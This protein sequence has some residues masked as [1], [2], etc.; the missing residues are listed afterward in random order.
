MESSRLPTGPTHHQSTSVSDN[1]HL[2]GI[3]ETR[4]RN[5][6][7]GAFLLIF[8]VGA[9][10]FIV[11]T[12]VLNGVI[13]VDTARE[14]GDAGDVYKRYQWLILG[15]LT[16][17]QYGL[18]L[19]LSLLVIRRW[20]TRRLIS[21]LTLDTLSVAGVIATT[22][23]ALTLLPLVDLLARYLYSLVPGLDSLDTGMGSLLTADTV[24]GRLLIYF[25]I[26]VTPAIC[27]EVLF[28]AYFQRTLERRIR[29]PWHFL[30]SGS[31][32]ALFH[33]QVLTLPS[34][35][36]VGV[37][38]SYMYFAFRTPWATMA[39]HFAYN[40]I[41]IF[42]VNYNRPIPGIITEDGFTPTALAAGTAITGL[43]LLFAEWSRRRP[44]ARAAD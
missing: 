26:A 44:A 9:V 33:Q 10:Y 2:T 35:A 41:Q 24:G 6:L 22:I 31:V 25:G 20:H 11:Q 42:L 12:I 4:D 38:L 1:R 29:A 39:A 19:G 17:T 36:L 32:F 40:G 3:W 30:I 43:T 7:V 15:V 18:L 28:R 13:I 14:A 37:F 21:Y 8:A 23:G 5:P 27:E 34:L 16:A